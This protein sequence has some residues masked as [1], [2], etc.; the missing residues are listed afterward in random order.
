MLINFL[1]YIFILIQT[2]ALI[3]KC[4][5]KTWVNEMEKRNFSWEKVGNRKAKYN[6][7]N[8]FFLLF[9]CCGIS[10]E[11][12]WSKAIN[13]VLSRYVYNALSNV[14]RGKLS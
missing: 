10:K 5:E 6:E 8:D 1:I 13:F 14:L 2:F 11:K 3:E 9:M 7:L 12:G 4:E